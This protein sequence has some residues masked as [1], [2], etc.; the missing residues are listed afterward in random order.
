[1]EIISVA[2]ARTILLFDVSQFNPKGLNLWPVCEKL[3][4]K[5]HFAKAPKNLLDLDEQKALSFKFGS[6]VNS[7]GVDISISFSIFNNG[8]VLDSLSSTDDTDECLDGIIEW[9][10]RD[11]GLKLP[12][13]AGRG[14]L[15]QLELESNFSFA[16]INPQVASLMKTLSTTVPTVDGKPH[17]FDFGV[18]QFWTDDVNP[19]TSPAYFRFER[20]I[21]SPFHLNRYFSQAALKTNDHK[22]FLGQFEKLV[23]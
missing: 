1:M 13:G 6:F 16:K 11:Y 19:A 20:K 9:V 21:G 7:K 15:S 17:N 5:Y 3:I 10:A 8:F 4:E 2:L 12:P 14:Y 18:L 22:D 23:S